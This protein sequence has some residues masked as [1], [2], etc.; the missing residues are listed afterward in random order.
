MSPGPLEPIEG[1]VRDQDTGKPLAGIMVRGERSLSDSTSVYVQS[2]SDAEGKYRLVGLARG[3][4]GHVVA[5]P[6]CDFPVY[7]SRKA[8]LKVPRDE[9][10]PYLRARVR[11]KTSV[12]RVRCAWTSA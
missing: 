4:E 5:V 7:G 8:E 1:F 6:P 2:I 3:K 10:L 12:G 11:S 9:E